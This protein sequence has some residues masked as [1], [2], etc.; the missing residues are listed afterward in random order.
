[1]TKTFELTPKELSAARILVQ[2]CLD[3]MGGKRPA[4]L[5]QDEYTWVDL[6]DLMESGLNRHE[7]AGV[8]GALVEKGFVNGKINASGK[9]TDAHVTTAGWRWMDTGWGD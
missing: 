7:A 8:F 6:N 4:D 9:P 5:E 3:N 2:S 1:M